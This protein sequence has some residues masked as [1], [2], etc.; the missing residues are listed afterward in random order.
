LNLIFHTLFVA[1]R[2]S[3]RVAAGRKC[4]ACRAYVKYTN[5]IDL[6]LSHTIC[7]LAILSARCRVRGYRGDRGKAS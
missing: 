5:A 7:G 4:D 6:N 2:S 1:S 3:A